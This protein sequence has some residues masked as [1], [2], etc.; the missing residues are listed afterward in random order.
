M[1]P[2][3]LGWLRALTGLC[4]KC[5]ISATPA[6][7]ALDLAAFTISPSMSYPWISTFISVSTSSLASSMASYQHLRLIRFLHSSE[8]KERFIPGAML[9]ASMAA[10]M[11]NVPLPQNGSTRIR[12]LF[13]GVSIIRAAARVSVMG[14]LL[15]SV[16]YPRLC[17]ESPLVSMPTVTMS[18]YRKTRRG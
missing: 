10:S 14:A 9:A 12:S 11:G 2:Y 15:V 5:I 4:W 6:D 17:R 8:R 7:S 13:H 18:L 1:K 3:F 16:L